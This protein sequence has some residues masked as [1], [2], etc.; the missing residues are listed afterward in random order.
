MIHFQADSYG[1]TLRGSE[2]KPKLDRFLNNKIKEL[3]NKGEID[4]KELSYI[5]KEKGALKYKVTIQ[6]K[7]QGS[8]YNLFE[9]RKAFG[10]IYGNRNKTLLLRNCQLT[11][12]CMNPI[13]QKLIED[14]L[15]EFFA[16][17]NFGY[18]QNKGFGSFMP[19]EYLQ[20]KNIEKD[21]S[22]WLKNK[23]GAKACY[24][25]DFPNMVKKD[26]ASY[27]VYFRAIKDSYDY[28]NTKFLKIV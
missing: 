2:L 10:I 12:L 9:N 26:V 25:M 11:I 5:D 15:V 7:G 24:Y 22:K 16:V 8:E 3:S 23:C 1:A 6:E 17:T 4:K 20:E 28:L 14:Y 19:L 27:E 13:L 21:V 18:M